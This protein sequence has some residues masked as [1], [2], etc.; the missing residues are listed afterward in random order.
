MNRCI[1]CYRCVRFYRDYAGGRDLQTL[2]AHDNVYFGRQCNG[3]LE[4]PFAGNLVEVCPTGVFTDET[5]AH[6]FVRNWDLSNAPSVCVHCGIGC[7]T[8]PGER[9]GSVRRIRARYNEAVN[10]FFLCDR[11][12]FGY[13]FVNGDNRIRQPLA[14]RGKGLQASAL[15]REAALAHVAAALGPGIPVV[16]VGSP[17]A[18]VEANF[19]LRTLVGQQNFY[20]GVA[21][22]EHELVA[23]VLDVLTRGAVRS[24][25][26][27]DL[28]RSDAV[29]VLGE[30]VTNTSPMADLAIRQAAVREPRARAEKLGIP[31]WQ[32]ASLRDVVQNEKGP[33]FVLTSQP[34]ALDD[35]ARMSVHAP[36]EEVVRLAFAVAHVLDAAAPAVL[37]SSMQEQ[38]VAAEIAAALASATRPVIVGGTASRSAALLHACANVAEALNKRRSGFEPSVA[39][40]LCV[41]ECNSLGL[42]MLGGKCIDQATAMLTSDPATATIIVLENDLYERLPAAAIDELFGRARDV[43]VLDHLSTRHGR[44]RNDSLTGGYVC[45]IGRH[46]H[47]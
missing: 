30:D 41:P 40:F 36:P 7:N 26:L 47:Q 45:R 6:H 13:E 39:L 38:Q 29:L 18:S 35:V 2:G 5:Q 20:Q 8:L 25:S 24:A 46:V 21:P 15:T 43:V 12:R 42:A 37:D 22:L 3:V 28:A 33:L 19:A 9:A 32:D 44:A 27:D 23:A 4:S 10:G 11:G 16:G 17:R 14:P 31:P 34:T 1:A